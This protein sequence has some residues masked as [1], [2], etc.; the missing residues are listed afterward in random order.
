MTE[1]KL[2]DHPL[3]PYAQKVKIALNEKGIDYRTELPAA[4]GSGT[5]A[6]EFASGSPRGEVPLL[7]HGDVAVFDSTVIL[8]YIEDCW[9]EPPLL[10]AAPA[11]RA[12]V[13]MLE[14][15]LDTHV[16]AINWGLSEILYFKRAEGAEAEAILA[17]GR[18]QLIDWFAWLA[19]Q[20]GDREWFNGSTFGWGDL[21]VLPYLNGAA[22]FGV[23]PDQPELQRWVERTNE[24]PTVQPVV[25]AAAAVGFDSEAVSLEAVHAALEQGLFKREY[26]DH[27]L[28]WMIKTAG[29]GIVE[30]GLA[31][32]N[33]R[34]TEPF[35]VAGH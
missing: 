30:Q 14:D 34:F 19:A 27:R 25:A 17:R 35:P 16:E 6:G 26:R 28:E 32:G 31:R 5:T 11:E 10:P 18:Q 33:I 4:L 13:R 12:R 8:E 15:A 20:L 1:L 2:Y 22:G 24:R 29:L 3:S 9:P 7:V 21:A 23:R